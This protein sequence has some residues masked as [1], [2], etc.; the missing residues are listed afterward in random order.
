MG[1]TVTRIHYRLVCHLP[2]YA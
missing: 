1:H 2:E